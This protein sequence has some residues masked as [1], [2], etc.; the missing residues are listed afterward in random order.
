MSKMTSTKQIFSTIAKKQDESRRNF[1]NERIRKVILRPETFMKHAWTFPLISN[2]ELP[3][4]DPAVESTFHYRFFFENLS[5]RLMTM[6]KISTVF[7]VNQYSYM[8]DPLE[9]ADAKHVWEKIDDSNYMLHL[10]ASINR[11]QLDRADP[12]IYTPRIPLYIQVFVNVMVV[13]QYHPQPLVLVLPALFL[14][15]MV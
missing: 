4:Y 11:Y 3:P 5:D 14:L 15:E 12:P 13:V 8:F 7:Y 6:L 2:Y 10:H 1:D 9:W